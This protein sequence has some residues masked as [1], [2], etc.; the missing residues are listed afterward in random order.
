M[1]RLS[2][3][4]AWEET[5]LR[6]ASDGRLLVSVAAALFALPFAVIEAVMPAGFS[7]D[8][9]PAWQFLLALILILVLMI[10]Q[11][12]VVRLAI[13]PSVSV[14]EAIVHGL[15]RLGAY[16]LANILIGIGLT[17][18]I[19]IAA[20]VLFSAGVQINESDMPLTVSGLLLYLVTTPVG[21]VTLLLIAIYCFVWV[22]VVAMCAPVASAEAVGPLAIIRRSWEL[23][24]NH[25]WRVFGF[26]LLFFVG[27]SI[28]VLAIG[29]VVGLLAGLLLGPMDPLSLSALIVALIDAVLNAA[30]ITV[31]TVMLARIYVQ[32]SGRGSIDVSVPS[33]GT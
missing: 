7:Q 23:T 5:K 14:G 21:A 33:S 2:I 32:L 11:V 29:S 3:S 27:A 28:A 1:H 9:T 26:G 8:A 16:L 12:A 24:A 4:L 20:V 30:I 17:T 13:G 15:R 31:L 18:V 10:G 6:L 19:F 25:F 22:R